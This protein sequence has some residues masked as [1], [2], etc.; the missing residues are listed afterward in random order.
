MFKRKL[1]RWLVP[2][3][4][5]ALTLGTTMTRVMA[6]DDPSGAVITAVTAGS[7]SAKLVIAACGGVV[8]TLAVAGAIWLL[9]GGWIKKA[10]GKGH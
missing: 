1:N 3:T 2:C 9:G 7:S 4:V 6:D 5:A 8:I 10:I